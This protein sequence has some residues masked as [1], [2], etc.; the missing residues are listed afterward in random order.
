MGQSIEIQNMREVPSDKLEPGMVF[1]WHSDPPTYAVVVAPFTGDS[2]WDVK[3]SDK[4]VII[5][6]IGAPSPNYPEDNI[7]ATTPSVFP[8]TV[9]DEAEAKMVLLKQ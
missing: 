2:R 3:Y 1:L 7:F 9:L 5:K 4:W 8:V 6:P